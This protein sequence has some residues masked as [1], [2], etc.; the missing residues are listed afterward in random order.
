MIIFSQK[1]KVKYYKGIHNQNK[2][3]KNIFPSF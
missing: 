1:I 2:D 3:S